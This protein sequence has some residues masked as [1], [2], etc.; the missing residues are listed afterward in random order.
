MLMSEALIRLLKFWDAG[1]I[2]PLP[3]ELLL[4]NV[5]LVLFQALFQTLQKQ[6]A[7]GSWGPK[8]SR[9]TT[10]YAIIALSNLASLPFLADLSAQIQTAIERGR[11]YIQFDEEAKH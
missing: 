11:S 4:D 5:V 9:E 1:V 7:N 8:P 10:A 6:N 2:N 3:D